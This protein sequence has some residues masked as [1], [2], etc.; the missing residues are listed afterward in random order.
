MSEKIYIVTLHNREDLDGFYDDMKDNGF[1][2]NMK[3]PIS[4]NTHYWMTDEQAEELKQDPR[5]WD[6]DLRPE[7]R[8]IYPKKCAT[9]TDNQVPRTFE[10]NFWK[11]GGIDTN[12]S[13]PWGISHTI[14]P[15]GI[16]RGKGQFGSSGGTYNQYI[17]TI[18]NDNY[19]NAWG[20]G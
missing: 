12:N 3:R 1:R 11:A 13:L 4:R 19:E 18:P 2:L 8:G 16:A 17:T 14:D 9:P 5:V 20:D 15:T 6:V 10:G 7:D